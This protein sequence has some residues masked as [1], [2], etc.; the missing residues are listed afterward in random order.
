M[1]GTTKIGSSDNLSL[2]RIM[3]EVFVRQICDPHRDRH[4]T[5]IKQ[6]LDIFIGVDSEESIPVVTDLAN[7]LPSKKKKP[8]PGWKKLEEVNL[9]RYVARQRKELKELGLD[10]PPTSP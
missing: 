1:A 3:R 7:V 6:I 5:R 8:N 4:R 2:A 9:K 10:S